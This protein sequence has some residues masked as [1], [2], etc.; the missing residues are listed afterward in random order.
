MNLSL[1][2]KSFTSIDRRNPSDVEG[3]LS[4]SSYNAGSWIVGDHVQMMDIE[5]GILV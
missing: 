1:Y 2:R 5:T 4:I 3:W